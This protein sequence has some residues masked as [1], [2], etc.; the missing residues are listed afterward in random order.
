MTSVE[1]RAKVAARISEALALRAL[2]NS[3]ALG[4]ALSLLHYDL[5][6]MVAAARSEG[7]NEGKHKAMLECDIVLA[8]SGLGH[9]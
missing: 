7:E 3:E 4:M 6:D 5:D 2:G 1:A 8:Q 9:A